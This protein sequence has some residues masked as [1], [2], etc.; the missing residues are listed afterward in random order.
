MDTGPLD[1]HCARCLRPAPSPDDDEFGYWE[2]LGDEGQLAL[3]P[4][5]ITPEEQQAM[6]EAIMD[7]M[8]QA[9]PDVDDR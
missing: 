5:C 6:D 3:C 8:D 7:L 4:D 9:D 1:S 2:A